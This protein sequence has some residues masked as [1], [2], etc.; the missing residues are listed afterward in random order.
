MARDG[1]KFYLFDAGIATE[2]TDHDHEAIVSVLGA[3]IRR[4][5]QRAG[6]LLVDGN[7][8]Q[9]VVDAEGFIRKITDLNE[10]ATSKDSYLMQNLGVYI[11]YICKA[12]ADH[13]VHVIPSFISAALAVKVQEGIAIALDPSLSIIQVATPV[14]IQS[15][16]RRQLDKTQ[17]KL[18]RFFTKQVSS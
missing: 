11:S 4:N 6:E 14:V 17:K 10:K 15:E 2:Y 9:G 16:A 5:G 1:S 7:F 13:H 18:V 3:F 8:N 12:A